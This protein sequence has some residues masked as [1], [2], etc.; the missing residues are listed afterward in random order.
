MIG[1]RR[2]V[3]PL[4]AL[5]AC[6]LAGRALEARAQVPDAPPP[7]ELERPGPPP[8]EDFEVDANEDG[9]PDGWYN[10]RDARFARGG[11]GASTSRCL[12]F[13]NRRPGRE[14]RASRAFGVDGR[15]HQAIVVG[16]WV[17]LPEQVRSG[18]RVGQDPGLLI[19]FFGEGLKTLRRGLMG[20][21]SS[22]DL[23]TGWVFVS[24]RLPI[25]PDT[26]DAILSVG[27]QGATGV[28]EIDAMT[29]EL[30]PN[31]IERS[32]SLV[33][34]GDF[35]LGDPTPFAWSV[36]R[37][38]G[39]SFPGFRSQSALELDSSGSK[40]LTLLARPVASLGRLE[41]RLM[42]KASRLR[43][44]GGAVAGLFFLDATGVPVGSEV[45]GIPLLRWGGSHDWRPFQASAAVPPGAVR[46]VLQFEKLDATGVLS[47]D[48]VRITSAPGDEGQTWTPYRVELD[49]RGWHPVE[50][51]L[52]IEPG[53][54]LDASTW[55]GP[56]RPAGSSGLVGVSRGRLH[57]GGGQGQRA[58]FFGAAFLP[59]TAFL[60][61]GRADGLIDRLARSGVNLVRLGEL[62]A[63]LGPGRSLFDD[64]RDDTQGIDP[65]ALE[66]FDHLVAGLK[67]RGIHVAV[68]LHAQRRF[69]EGDKLGA[70][71][72]VPPG[73]GPS[74]GFEPLIAREIKSAAE[75]LLGHVNKETGTPLRDDPALAWVTLS[76]EISLFNLIDDP[77]TMPPA[78]AANLRAT[79]QRT[80]SGVGRRGWQ[81]LE[82]AHWR[83]IA[84]A[85]R[86]SGV[87]APIASVAH[88]R[89]EP[90]FNAA[91]TAPGFDL[92]DDRLFWVPRPFADPDT[93]SMLWE[94]DGGLVALAAPKRKAD[95]PY[96]VG[97]WCAQTSGAWALTHEAADLLLASQ[98]AV[99]EDWDALVRRGVFVYPV[100]WGSSAT[101]TGGVEN[102]FSVAE[103]INGTPQVYAL[104]PHAAS[105]Y[106][107][108]HEPAAAEGREASPRSTPAA[109]PGWD[110]LSGRLVL[111]TPFTQG[112]AGWSNGQPAICGAVTVECDEPFAVV[113]ASSATQQPLASTNRVLVTAVGQVVPSGFRW[114]DENRREV[115]DPGFPPLLQQPIR[116]KVTWKR[117][118]R[119]PV[120]G[121]VLSATGARVRTVPVQEI[122]GGY[123][124]SID[125]MDAG[126][127]WEL[128]VD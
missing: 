124:L 4:A 17:R 6:L 26:R 90:E 31:E 42:A 39:R 46:A 33:L 106:R 69:R 35:E 70:L 58:R 64:T 9:A 45:R 117:E 112:L 21:W 61:P 44:S 78:S 88:W 49:T 105:L 56:V 8:R 1:T 108:G 63:P 118:A 66:H 87:K 107:R 114:V 94:R 65:L 85:L 116:A 72:P 121:Y 113:V 3:R 55:F 128:V 57:F 98:I 52:A 82:T 73:G 29:F 59:P 109:V 41:V 77:T 119:G 25:P 51:S 40:A 24:K 13:E 27:L 37:G 23:G 22:K 5:L 74:A 54:A 102:I 80:A 10:L 101:G 38:A 19:D 32:T 43:G 12:R 100:V 67:A 110:P 50:P 127:H 30:I 36:E 99:A 18:E 122:A 71:G 104:L 16:L 115:A 11:V 92:V 20:S 62:D 95:Q 48:D 68:E 75:E 111:D 126:M 76:G 34:N 86:D 123:R 28:L 120:R 84:E 103:V 89:R 15:V 60:D 83:S 47:V 91:V 125:G 2:T 7:V 81:A 53:S 14:A 96:V 79:L 93:R 97:Q